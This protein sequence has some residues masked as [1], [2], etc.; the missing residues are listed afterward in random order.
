MS[1]L[2]YFLSPSGRICRQSFWLGLIAL[3]AIS[4]PVT[5]L[6]E[7]ELVAS[8]RDKHK[9]PGLASTL[10]NLLL[11]WPS[12]AISIKRFNDRD[13]PQW[14][15]YL[16]G[17]AMA[18]IILANHYG[19]LLDPEHMGSPEKFV[20]FLLLLFFVWSVIDNGFFKGTDGPNRYG[21]DPLAPSPPIA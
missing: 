21:P 13:R 8:M 17:A 1:L 15:G 5:T 6:L 14:V 2:H 11:T 3:M 4:L 7:P 16:L 18:I 9:P 19:Y 20:F 10:W 12:A